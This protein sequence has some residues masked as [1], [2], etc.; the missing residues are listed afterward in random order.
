M[1]TLSTQPTPG[2]GLTGTPS[3]IEWAEEIKPRVSAEFDRV[4]RPSGGCESY[5]VQDQLIAIGLYLL[6]GVVLT[7]NA[8]RSAR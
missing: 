6:V 2:P 5:G 3:Q 4:S 8:A 1:D 7:A